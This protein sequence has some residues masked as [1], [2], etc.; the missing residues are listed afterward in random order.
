MAKAEEKGVEIVLAIDCV[1]T[2]ESGEG[3]VIKTADLSPGI[4]EGFHGFG[5]R[6]T[7]DSQ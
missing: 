1:Y 6:P 4:P 7:V 5:L 2:S 3:A